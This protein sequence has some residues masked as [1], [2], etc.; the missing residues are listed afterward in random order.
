MTPADLS[1]PKPPGSPSPKLVVLGCLAALAALMLLVGGCAATTAYKAPRVGYVGVCQSGGPFDDRGTCGVSQAGSGKRF[2]GMFNTLREY[3][4]TQRNYIITADVGRGDRG[5]VDVVNLPTSD[6]VKVG[7]EGQALFTLDTT[8]ANLLGFYRKYGARSFNGISPDS[9]DAWW[10]AFLDIQFRPILDNALR[11]EILRYDCAELNPGCKLIKG[12][13]TTGAQ[14]N[15]NLETI[16]SNIGKTLQAD[17]TATLG[18][19]FFDNVRFRL[20]GVSLPGI[21]QNIDAANAAKADVATA[22]FEANKRVE[23]AKGDRRV[24]EQQAASIRATQNAYRDNPAQARIDTVKALPKSLQALGGN[25]S[26]IIG[27]K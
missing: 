14:A 11:Q 10:N 20:T 5:G 13:A 8:P 12:G 27:A 15:R 3:P 23:Q 18:G 16:Q 21:Q 25:V 22:R 6:G 2:L 24:A 7:L 1:L 17:L 26:S 4:A 19:D 9:A